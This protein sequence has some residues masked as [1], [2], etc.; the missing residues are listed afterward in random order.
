MIHIPDMLLGSTLANY[1]HNLTIRI[2]T[3]RS[4]AVWQEDVINISSGLEV[5]RAMSV[6]ASLSK[7]GL[8]ENNMALMKLNAV[9]Y[10]QSIPLNMF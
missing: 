1:A 2:D 3:E 8:S 6:E 9:T 5:S 7:A 10:P 4:Q